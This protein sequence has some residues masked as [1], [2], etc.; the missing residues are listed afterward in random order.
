MTEEFGRAP[1]WL[2]RYHS[3]LTHDRQLS[4]LLKTYGQSEA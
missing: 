1:E 4:N 3:L 2:R